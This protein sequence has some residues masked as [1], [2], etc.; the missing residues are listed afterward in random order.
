MRYVD[1]TATP[2]VITQEVPLPLSD[3]D[4]GLCGSDGIKLF[5]GSHYYNYVSPMILA[6]GRIAP[7]PQMITSEMM[8]CED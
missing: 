4:A 3:I 8:G 7:M 5:K 2:R 6:M 1:L